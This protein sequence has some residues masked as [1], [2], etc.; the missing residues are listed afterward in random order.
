M[1]PELA[2]ARKV[3]SFPGTD[4]TP[5]GRGNR[6]TVVVVS[7]RTD[8]REFPDRT[9]WI[10]AQ[11]GWDEVAAFIAEWLEGLAGR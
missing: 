2:R 9:H 11:E 10:I 1:E 3:G 4:S 7:S 6:R 8:I 5:H